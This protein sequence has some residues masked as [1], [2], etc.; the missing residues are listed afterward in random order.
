MALEHGIPNFATWLLGDPKTWSVLEPTTWGFLL[1]A[2]AICLLLLLVAPFIC[3]VITSLQYGP[4]EAFYYV[5]RAMF[6]AVTEDLPRFSPRRTLAV[7]RLAIQEAIRNRVLV[8]FGVF[9]VLLLFAGLFLD[10]KNSNPSRVYLSFVL[11]TTNYLVL[12]MALMLS[13]FSIP[14]DIKNRTIYTVVTKPIRASEIVLGRTLGF[15]AVGTVMLLGMGIISYF[16]V[17]RGLAHDHQIEMTNL[18]EEKNA[19]GAVRHV[20]GETTMDAHHR[21][22]FELGQDGKGRTSTAQGH[23]HDIERLADGKYRV[24][25]PQGHLIAKAPIYGQL[26]IYGRDG[27]PGKGIN[28]GNEW[29]YRGYIEGGTPGVQT[30]ANAVWTFE[31]VT[32][33]RY[34]KGLPL[35]LNLRVFRTYKGNIEQGVLGEIVIR[36]PNPD[37]KI[38]RSGPILFESK[39]FV[40][41]QR[42]IPRELNSEIGG[43]A[44]AGKLDLFKDLVHNG[45]VEVEVRCVDSAQYF[46]VAEPDVYLRPGDASFEFNFLKA[47]LS[48]WLQ[49]ML[50]TSFGVTFSTFLSGPVALLASISA[51]V[52]GFFG[53]FVRDIATGAQ[54]G[55]GPI[56]STIRLITQMNVM[57]EMEINKLLDRTIKVAD[58]G[59]M[60]L[61]QAATYILPDYTQFDTAEFVADGYNIFGALVFQQLAMAAVYFTVVTVVGYFFLK[62]REIAA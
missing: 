37:A 46:G 33:Q 35:E 56:E 38:R 41:D 10:V 16:F 28:V 45:K 60:H 20:S 8:G 43:S 30:K 31:G 47:Y 25:P 26:I 5:A 22:K 1:G 42:L 53:Q 32:E 44:G 40:A 55:G 57:T 13:A 2:V 36:N 62:T 52:L 61:L 4:S 7:A 12:L 6:S 50:I 17:T 3:F 18:V 58:G 9:I 24:G 19:E 49:M 48:I 27:N 21:H 23:W 29:E 54:Y 59:L 14:N 34:P 15:A 11:T 39:E 51:M